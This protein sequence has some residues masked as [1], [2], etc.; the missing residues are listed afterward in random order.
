VC[1]IAAVT[2]HLMTHLMGSDRWDGTLMQRR[3]SGRWS[4]RTDVAGEKPIPVPLCPLQIA[5]GLG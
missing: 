3:L 4:G 1:D 5:H 2:V